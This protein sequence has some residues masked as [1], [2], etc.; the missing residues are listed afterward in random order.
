[1][2]GDCHTTK[3]D[4]TETV[5]HVLPSGWTMELAANCRDSSDDGSANPSDT[6]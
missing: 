5:M 2:Q 4:R 6:C 1:M 3:G